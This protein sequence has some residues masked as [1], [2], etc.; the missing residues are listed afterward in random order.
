MMPM[1]STD[2]KLGRWPAVTIVKCL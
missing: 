2:D 1:V